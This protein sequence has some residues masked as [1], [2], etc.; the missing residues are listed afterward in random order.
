MII[1]NTLPVVY[2]LYLPT[3]GGSTCDLKSK[4]MR[5]N[6]PE[7]GLYDVVCPRG[8]FCVLPGTLVKLKRSPTWTRHTHLRSQR[9]VPELSRRRQIDQWQKHALKQQD[10]EEKWTGAR[11]R[12]KYSSKWIIKARCHGSKLYHIGQV[13][14]QR[15]GKSVCPD[16]TQPSPPAACHRSNNSQRN[17]F[18][19]H[20][21]Q[22]V[23]RCIR[24]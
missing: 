13:W 1:A 17:L 10:R 6:N 23:A 3:A 15:C 12:E 8:I 19:N 14:S 18:F 22:V 11:E 5:T 7:T 16:K 2:S 9:T 21:Q 20:A 4:N 24:C